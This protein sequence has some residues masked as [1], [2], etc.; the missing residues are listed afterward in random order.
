VTKEDDIT[1]EGWHFSTDAGWSKVSEVKGMRRLE[2]LC[3]SLLKS[4]SSASEMVFKMM[5]ECDL[6]GGVLLDDE[7][8]TDY[9][10]DTLGWILDEAC[11]DR[12][13]E[14]KSKA[15]INVKAWTTAGRECSAQVIVLRSTNCSVN[16]A[17]FSM[18]SYAFWKDIDNW[19]QGKFRRTNIS[20][21]FYKFGTHEKIDKKLSLLVQYD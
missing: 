16:Y 8:E 7:E 20:G 5:V 1:L 4:K 21:S 18:T 12:S 11:F 6:H 17:Y 15:N 2:S 9:Y 3:R 10:C 14:A 13:H 19:M